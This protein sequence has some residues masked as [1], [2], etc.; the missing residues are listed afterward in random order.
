MNDKSIYE[1]AKIAS[2]YTVKCIE[3]TIED[4]SHWY[5]TKFETALKDLIAMLGL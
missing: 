4:E 2:D 1:S 3:N 5:G